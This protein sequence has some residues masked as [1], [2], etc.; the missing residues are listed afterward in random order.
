MV[1]LVLVYWGLT[2]ST[3]DGI[4]WYRDDEGGEIMA[5]TGSKVPYEE[6][7][8]NC[9]SDCKFL[10]DD[11]CIRDNEFAAGQT[12]EMDAGVFK[13]CPLYRQ[14]QGL[15]RWLVVDSN[16]ESMAVKSTAADLP[17]VV[18]W[19]ATDIVAIIRIEEA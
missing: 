11:G 10:T 16:G 5:E 7:T 6:P 17:N 13:L 18:E 19:A 8:Y 12:V 15:Y 4:I 14:Q 3:K 9:K 2:K 1:L